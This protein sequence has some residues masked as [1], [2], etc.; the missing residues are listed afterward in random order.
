MTFTVTFYRFT[1]FYAHFYT[2]LLRDAL[3]FTL[4]PPYGGL[5]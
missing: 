5:S 2:V 1:R 4:P 3:T